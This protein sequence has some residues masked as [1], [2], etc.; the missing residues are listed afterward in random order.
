MK[1]LLVPVEEP[2]ATEVAEIF[3]NYPKRNGYILQLFR[4][5]ANSTRFL[6]KGTVNLLDRDSPIAMR[7]R[8]ILILRVCANNNC[9]Y[10]WGVHV[11]AFGEHVG[12]T[13]EQIAATRTGDEKSPCW[14]GE[15]SLLIQLVDELCDRGELSDQTQE[16][17]QEAW[18][19]EQQLEILALCGNYHTISFVANTARLKRE[20]FG[21]TFPPSP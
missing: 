20:S 9:E 12:F 21:A 16:L 10:E 15:E 4:V 13:S 5:F 3:E 19:Q 6:K 11:T 8:E 7:Q 14:V 1:H 18:T 2:F 17:F